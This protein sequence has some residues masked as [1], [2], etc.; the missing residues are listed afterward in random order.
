MTILQPF[1]KKQ[2]LK[3]VHVRQSGLDGDTS[4]GIWR[5]FDATASDSDLDEFEDEKEDEE[6]GEEEDKW[7][8]EALELEP[9]QDR[10]SNHSQ[11]VRNWQR[12]PGM[13]LMYKPR[14][15][16]DL[17]FFA[18]W[19]FGPTGI[20]SLSVIAFGD[21]SYNER[22]ASE[23]VFLCRNELQDKRD[24]GAHQRYNYRQITSS[25]H[26][27]WGLVEKHRNA[28]EA[29]PTSSLFSPIV[30]NN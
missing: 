3:V 6:D 16:Q 1:T 22:Y 25:D 10:S 9:H 29:C 27:A 24:V 28:L 4:W 13:D 23:N 7:V 5:T 2:T 8:Y 18:N 14:P 17:H 30:S 12:E 11:L 26:S 19:A 15:T 20:Q 21:F